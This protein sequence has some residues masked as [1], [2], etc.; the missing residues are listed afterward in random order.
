MEYSLFML[1]LACSLV[2]IP[3]NAQAAEAN[4]PSEKV[5]WTHMFSSKK[6]SKRNKAEKLARPTGPRSAIKVDAL[7][8]RLAQIQAGPQSS[9]KQLEPIELEREKLK[10]LAPIKAEALVLVK[11]ESKQTIQDLIKK[12]DG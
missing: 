1:A 6:H 9:V 2:L 3:E 10:K 5:S 4:S 11:K 8:A 12:F 7:R